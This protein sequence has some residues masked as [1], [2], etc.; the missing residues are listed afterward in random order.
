MDHVVLVENIVCSANPNTIKNKFSSFGEICSVG[1]HYNKFSRKVS[2]GCAFVRY[3]QATSAQKAVKSSGYVKVGEFR[4]DV[5]MLAAAANEH[6]FF[7]AMSLTCNEDS[8]FSSIIAERPNVSAKVVDSVIQ[9]LQNHKYQHTFLGSFSKSLVIKDINP[10][11]FNVGKLHQKVNYLAKTVD[12]NI[13]WD[14]SSNS[15][16]GLIELKS[17]LQA[18]KVARYLDNLEICGTKIR[19][20]SP[21][22][23][24]DSVDF[25]DG[26]YMKNPLSFSC[27][28]N[29][30]FYYPGSPIG[31]RSLRSCLIN[32][33]SIE[34]A[35]S[36]SENNSNTSYKDDVSELEK[37]EQCDTLK[38]KG[39]S[40]LSTANEIFNNLSCRE[41][42]G[43][44]TMIFTDIPEDKTK[45]WYG[46]AYL[47]FKSVDDLTKFD[48]PSYTIHGVQ[49]AATRAN[50]DVC[51]SCKS[52]KSNNSSVNNS[53]LDG[54][55]LMITN[56]GQTHSNAFNIKKRLNTYGRVKSVSLHFGSLAKQEKGLAIVDILVN[57]NSKTIPATM[58]MVCKSNVSIKKLSLDSSGSIPSEIVRCLGFTE[59]N[60]GA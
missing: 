35:R 59:C 15:G 34:Y 16:F 52:F 18:K 17:F 56:L 57:K 20:M 41:Q 27:S 21:Q 40:P 44:I 39:I 28:G 8:E 33:S 58:K 3:Q 47:K 2:N 36:D 6:P 7:E 11:Q 13:L 38:L 37:T 32:A 48:F 10:A 1:L 50:F 46:D 24:F 14:Y 55:V 30:S 12:F 4:V 49:V 54:N 42:V 26:M 19:V 51:K 5:C 45:K 53:N 29:S 60:H 22:T 9:L 43:Q 25:T 31:S 23:L